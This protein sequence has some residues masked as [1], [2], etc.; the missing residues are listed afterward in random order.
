MKPLKKSVLII[1][2]LVTFLCGVSYTIKKTADHKKTALIKIHKEQR[3]L[4]NL[5]ERYKNEGTEATPITADFYDENSIGPFISELINTFKQK[6]I[7]LLSVKPEQIR[8]CAAIEGLNEF[9]I[10][11][12]IQ[13]AFNELYTFLNYLENA[14]YFILMEQA[15]FMKVNE[16]T[17]EA[18]LVLAIPIL[19]NKE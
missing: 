6:N 1:I 9:P 16:T 5:V 15:T 17:T 2:G 12:K 14:K 13:G 4:I 19:N 11:I 18:E 3:A 8:E 7:V 10:T